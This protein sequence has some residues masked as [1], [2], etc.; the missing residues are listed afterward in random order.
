MYELYQLKLSLNIIDQEDEDE[1]E[2]IEKFIK[3]KKYS[4]ASPLKPPTPP[5]IL[6]ENKV[7]DKLMNPEELK[8]TYSK[9]PHSGRN[10]VVL[11][12]ANPELLITER[13]VLAT[14]M[15]MNIDPD[16]AHRACKRLLKRS[17]D[18]HTLQMV[19]YCL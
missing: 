15:E 17:K 1:E 11:V 14:L 6:D 16:Q 9:S 10:T 12:D 8:E 5:K 3:S 4:S 13:D 18:L 2:T 7:T 19:K